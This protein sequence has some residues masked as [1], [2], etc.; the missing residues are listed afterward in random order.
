MLLF[1]RIT[2]KDMENS[3]YW[4]GTLTFYNQHKDMEVTHIMEIIEK[5]DFQLFTD[6][7]IDRGHEF[8][9][10]SD[11]SEFVISG[12]VPLNLILP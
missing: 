8:A 2:R 11:K 9:F 10:D 5:T 4:N 1:A 12:F 6:A 7:L 3:S